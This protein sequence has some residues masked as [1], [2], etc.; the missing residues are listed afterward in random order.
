MP[1]PYA[2]VACSIGCH[3]FAG[4]SRPATSPGNPVCGGVPKPASES[5][6]HI[7]SG[8]SDSA[9][10]AA[11][12]FDDFWITCSTV[13]A[14]FGCASWIVAVPIVSVPGAGLDHRVGRDLAGFERGGDRERL[15][16]RARLEHVGQR[17][18]AHLLARDRVARLFGLYVGQLASARISPVCASRIT[19]A[20]G[21]RLVRLDRGLELA[22]R[23]VLQPRVD[24]RARGRGRPAAR[25]SLSTSSTTSPRRL[26]IT[27]RLPGLP[28]S[29]SCCASSM[30][31]WPASSIAGEADDVARH[32]AAG[33]VA[34][35]L[36]LLVQPGDLQRHRARR[37][38]GRRSA[39]RGRRSRSSAS[40]CASSAC[41]VVSSTRAS[42]RELRPASPRPAPGI[43]QIDFT[44]VE[45]ASGSPL[46]STM[47]PRC[48]GTSISRL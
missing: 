37:R 29:Q 3:V 15:Q 30:P 12:T 32:L 31:S 42:A 4:R 10:F 9:I 40:S 16:R 14:P 38:L 21:L 34:A 27:R 6:C 22:E 8:G 23:E 13:S 11:P 47:R 45:I 17:A 5:I 25:G 18:V 44:G 41:G 39:S 28:P 46:R 2:I 43:A 24:R 35:V 1:W 33:V 36:V 26:M 20:A 7:V 19:S 48:A